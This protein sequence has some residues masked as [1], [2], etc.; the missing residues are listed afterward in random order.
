MK[1]IK[2]LLFTGI[3]TGLLLFVCIFA[4]R[5]TKM[6]PKIISSPKNISFSQNNILQWTFKNRVLRKVLGLNSDRFVLQRPGSKPSFKENTM[7]FESRGIQTFL[8]LPL[9]QK[10]DAEKIK[11][12]GLKLR[13]QPE[14]NEQQQF[15]K[16][17]RGFS[18]ELKIRFE[19]TGKPLELTQSL[20]A[21]NTVTTC[22][23]DMSS[24]SSWTG[25]IDNIRIFPASGNGTVQ[26]SEIQY[27][28]KNP[29]S[30]MKL[31]RSTLTDN[32]S[33]TFRSNRTFAYDNT[34]DSYQ[35]EGKD[36]RFYP[37][38]EP[39][40]IASENPVLSCPITY[41]YKQSSPYLIYLDN[42]GKIVH[43]DK[44][45]IQSERMEKT[46]TDTK[47]GN[48]IALY[49]PADKEN[50]KIKTLTFDQT[51]TELVAMNNNAVFCNEDKFI[52]FLTKSQKK[53]AFLSEAWK[54]RY[55]T[56]KIPQK[57]SSCKINYDVVSL[58]RAQARI[59]WRCKGSEEIHHGYFPA[60]AEK[61]NLS[62]YS[63]YTGE[64]HSFAIQFSNIS[65]SLKLGNFAFQKD[66]FE[67]KHTTL[68]DRVYQT[69]FLLECRGDHDSFLYKNAQY[70]LKSRRLK[71]QLVST[72]MPLNPQNEE[73]IKLHY[74]MKGPSFSFTLHTKNTIKNHKSSMQRYNQTDS[75]LIEEENLEE[76]LESISLNSPIKANW[77]KIIECRVS[78]KDQTGKALSLQLSCPENVT[79]SQ[80]FS[81]ISFQKVMDSEYIELKEAGLVKEIKI[82]FLIRY[83]PNNRPYFYYYENGQKQIKYIDGLRADGKNEIIEIYLPKDRKTPIYYWGLDLMWCPGELIIH[84]IEIE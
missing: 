73:K 20:P 60:T 83:L 79:Q 33:L 31:H 35:I 75:Y 29:Q 65:G 30:E 58:N 54:I 70:T 52:L 22:Y 67:E 59:T 62:R 12:I 78:G 49:L 42:N 17:I 15:L 27:L 41:Q 18:P 44:L 50:K 82:E 38:S 40:F 64:I 72:T 16:K 34:T 39:A 19:R 74:Q 77:L 81:N 45:S 11:C 21:T 76:T 55:I 23:F 66:S 80:E 36:I 10:L 56:Q 4:I 48:Y 26:L 46:D 5:F 53:P 63:N 6:R 57:I 61:W 68:A 2:Y 3:A 28:A 47:Q 71:G 43:S 7:T 14:L 8:D 1:W 51:E 13:I 24:L 25:I 32:K 84:R 37:I 9:T 69:G